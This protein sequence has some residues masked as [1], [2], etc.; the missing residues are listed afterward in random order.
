MTIIA[1]DGT[2]VLQKLFRIAQQP[3]K[4]GMFAKPVVTAHQVPKKAEQA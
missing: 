1:P 3:G 4:E 2:D